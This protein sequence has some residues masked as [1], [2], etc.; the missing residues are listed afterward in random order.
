MCPSAPP[1]PPP[2]PPHTHTH[3]N[4]AYE[5]DQKSLPVFKTGGWPYRIWFIVNWY[6]E[7]G[8]YRY[9]RKGHTVHINK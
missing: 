1:P 5:T 8:T 2:P 3:K 4:D 6:S 7:L 9:K